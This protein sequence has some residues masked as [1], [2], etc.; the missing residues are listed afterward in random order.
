MNDNN[1][2]RFDPE[3]EEWD[4]YCERLEAYFKANEVTEAEPMAAR[5]IALMGP[6]AYGV[7]RTLCAPQKP[8]ALAYNDL[9]VLFDGHYGV[10]H[11]HLAERTK[12]YARRQLPKETATLFLAALRCIAQ[13]CNFGD[14]LSDHL[15]DI[16]VSGMRSEA[17]RKRL[18]IEKDPKS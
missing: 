7:L 18:L 15:R 6:K 10:K 14:G 13:N 11:L 5:L 9:K 2:G 12:F 1:V 4:S 8:S 16:F 17:T 3:K